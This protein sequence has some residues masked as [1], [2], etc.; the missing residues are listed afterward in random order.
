M[1]GGDNEFRISSGK[2]R[3]AHQEFQKSGAARRQ[4]GEQWQG[5]GRHRSQAR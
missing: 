5:G 3:A 4:I 2:P 1:S